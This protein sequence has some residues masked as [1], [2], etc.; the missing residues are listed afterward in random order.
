M[1]HAAIVRF[2]AA[3]A[4]A[5]AVPFSGAAAQG[6]E[7]TSSAP[8]L[9]VELN[10]LQPTDNGCRFTFVVTNELGGELESAAFELVLFDTE[11]MVSRLTIVDFNDLP[12]GKTKVRQFDFTNVDCTK[13]GRVLINDATE[14][15]GTGIEPGDCI[16]SLK[17]ESRTDA[18]LGI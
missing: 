12:Q 13:L 1:R 5:V 10:A 17:T 16:R 2:L 7:E 6:A 4:L 11:G 3:A 15:K 8:G 18:E 14:C 9:L